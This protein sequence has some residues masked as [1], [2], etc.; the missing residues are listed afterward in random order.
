MSKIL[1]LDWESSITFIFE[2]LFDYRRVFFMANSVA[3]YEK[4]F[5]EAR[6]AGQDRLDII[7]IR[8]SIPAFHHLGNFI[9]QSQH[10]YNTADLTAS[11]YAA[12]NILAIYND[13][14]FAHHKKQAL[15]MISYIG[16][17]AMMSPQQRQESFNEQKILNNIFKKAICKKMGIDEKVKMTDEQIS[18]FQAEYQVQLQS[19]SE[20][21]QKHF[22]TLV[23]SIIISEKTLAPGKSDFASLAFVIVKQLSLDVE[24]AIME[25]IIRGANFSAG[26]LHCGTG[27]ARRAEEMASIA[28]PAPAQQNNSVECKN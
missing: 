12:G 13:K 20:E 11:V 8:K 14:Y 25:K 19:P 23:I 9:V 7:R 2:L 4:K 3:F 22:L 18:Q 24:A 15:L 16:L 10:V 5:T 21:V 1:P 28:R 6:Q 27:N 17:L 26:F